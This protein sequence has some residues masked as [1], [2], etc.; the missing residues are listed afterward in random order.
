MTVD[1]QRSPE[2]QSENNNNTIRI[3][4]IIDERKKKSLE[5]SYLQAF[6]CQKFATRRT[7]RE[8]MEGKKGARGWTVDGLN[9]GSIEAKKKKK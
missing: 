2:P 3:K 6:L 5:R 7:P 1:E 8:E 4:I 9:N